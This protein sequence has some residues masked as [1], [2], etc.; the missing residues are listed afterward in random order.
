VASGRFGE[1]RSYDSS[2][3]FGW[4]SGSGRGG[5]ASDGEGLWLGRSKP[6]SDSRVCM[7][8]EVARLPYIENPGF[9]QGRMS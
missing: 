3:W 6:V 5:S 2:Y 8:L 9:A 7:I 4:L 1:G